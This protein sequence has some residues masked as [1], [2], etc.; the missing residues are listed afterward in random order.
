[1][2]KN[3]PIYALIDSELLKKYNLDLKSVAKQL[4][5]LN[6]NIA[7]YRNKSGDLNDIA[8]DIQEFKS[9]FRGKLIINDYIE[10]IDLADGLHIGQEDLREIAPNPKEAIRALRAK[11]SRKILGLSTHNLDEIK[12]AN[13]LDLDYIGLGAYRLSS[14]KDVTSIKGEE[15]L[16]IAKYSIYPVALIGGVRFEDNF[17]SEISYK[18]LGSALFEKLLKL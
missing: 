6:I 8:K 16:E 15:L 7:Q 9:I 1:M 14:T 12:V 4:N 3:T 17:G 11:L 2:Q 13:T 10:L 18:V 5:N